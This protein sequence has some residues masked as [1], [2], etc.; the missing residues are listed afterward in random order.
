MLRSL[1]APFLGFFGL[2]TLMMW[3][4]PRHLAT[5]VI[6]AI[7]YWDAYTN[8]MAM[9]SRLR[10]VLGTGPGSHYT[11]Y[12]FAPIHDSLVFNESLFGL[13]LIYAPFELLTNE[14]LLAYNIT[15]LLSLTMAQYF[16]FLLVKRLSGSPW[17]AAIAGFAFAFSPY[18]TFEMG[19]IQ[20]VATQWIPL[21]F[22]FLHRALTEHRTRDTLGF[23]AAY[24]LQIG[25]CLY[26][27]MFMLPLLALMAGVLLARR[28]PG[29]RFWLGSL[30]VGLLTVPVVVGMTYPYFTSR[31]AF[32]LERADDFAASFDGKLE[33][34]TNVHD[35]NRTLTWMHHRTNEVGA[36]EEIAFPGFTITTLCLVTLLAPIWSRLRDRGV[37]AVVNWLAWSLAT[38]IAALLASTL[39]H[40]FLAGTAATAVMLWA[41]RRFGP[42]SPF[43]A[44]LRLQIWL[45]ILSVVMYLGMFPFTWADEP[46]HGLYYYFHKYVPG[47]NGIRKVSRQAC[48][49]TFMFLMLSGPGAR[50]LFFNL[51]RRWMKVSA[52]AI[53]LGFVCWEFRTFPNEVDPLWAGDTVPGAYRYIAAQ[54]GTRPIAVLPAYFGRKR[55]RAQRGMAIHNYMALHHR[56]RTLNGKSSFIPPVTEL[57]HQALRGLPDPNATRILNILDC[58][59]VLIHGE[60]MRRSRRQRV[61]NGLN[62]DR[63]H[64][65]HVFADGDMHVYR[66]RKQEDPTLGLLTMPSPPQG[67]EPLLPNGVQSS[68]RNQR[69]DRVIDGRM[70]TAWTTY[71]NMRRDD[72]FE[73]AF[74]EPVTMKML[75]LRTRTALTDHPLSF[76][77]S[78]ER[79]DGQLET[80]YTRPQIKMFREQVYHPKGF[81]FRAPLPAPTTTRRLRIT[82]EEPVSWRWWT[83]DEA[84]VWGNR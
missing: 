23:V 40:T 3:P 37:R 25:T 17:A 54:P 73:F 67:S 65:E 27:A 61:I 34:F 35:T 48:M 59:Y 52:L 6:A 38:L 42:G 75:E 72:W 55:F 46:V 18:A 79:E 76:R 57:V 7:Y 13:S 32:K 28:L 14:P 43:P 20:L 66:L 26:Y 24:L 71:R 80:I 78:V 2:T 8:T 9:S 10:N 39:T 53:L 69:S 11:S 56:R 21:C 41:F 36:H 45:L 84:R 51:P 44:L 70:D 4:L 49:T 30:L 81:V 50:T 12:F 83:I 47:F 68:R 74:D 15:L 62:A 31:D 58:E 82:V 29:R 16:M 63:K 77:L 19:R 22:L 64:Y 33:F 60:D 1:L 5:H